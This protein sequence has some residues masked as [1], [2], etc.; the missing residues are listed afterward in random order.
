MGYSEGGRA[1]TSAPRSEHA[2][3]KSAQRLNR[4]L[5][6]VSFLEEIAADLIERPAK[7]EVLHPGTEKSSPS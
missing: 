5:T 6:G 1:K 4:G 7:A 3:T 2:E